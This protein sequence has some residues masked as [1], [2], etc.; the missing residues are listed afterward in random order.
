MVIGSFV[1][2][3]L[4]TTLA[5]NGFDCSQLSGHNKMSP[6]DST[7]WSKICFDIKQQQVQNQQL[8][9][10]IIGIP[11]VVLFGFILKKIHC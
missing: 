1:I 9:I 7:G 4:N 2:G 3:V 10:I 8:L 5:D 11:A 6:T